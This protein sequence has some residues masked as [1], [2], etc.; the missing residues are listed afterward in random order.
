MVGRANDVKV[1]DGDCS[2]KKSLLIKEVTELSF[3][4]WQCIF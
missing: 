4:H 2:I 3:G 1:A